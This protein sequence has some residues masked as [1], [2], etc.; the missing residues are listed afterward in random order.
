MWSGIISA[1]AFC[2]PAICHAQGEEALDFAALGSGFDYTQGSYSLGFRFTANDNSRVTALGFYDDQKNGLT[3]AHPVGIYDVITR[4]LV[5]STTVL[6]SDPITGFFRYHAITPVTLTAGRDYFAMALSLTE[7]YAVSV[8]TLLVSPHITFVG[9]AGV[10][11]S[12]SQE[13]ALRYPDLDQQA[14]GF[15][16]DFG[17]SFK[18]EAGSSTAAAVDFSALDGGTNVNEA[19]FCMGYLFRPKRDIQLSTLGYYDDNRDGFK[20]SHLVGIFNATTKSLVASTLV[21]N[22]D[23]LRGYF[24]YHPVPPVTLTAGT[25]YFV[26]GANTYD[27]YAR[28]VPQG[29]F[30]VSPVITLEAGAFTNSPPSNGVNYPT[31]TDPAVYLFGPTFEVIGAPH[32]SNIS[33]RVQVQTGANVT[34]GGFIVQGSQPKQVLVRGLGPTLGRYGVTGFLADPVLALHQT[35]AAGHD[36]LLATNDNWKQTQQSLIQATGKAPPIDAEAAILATL[37]AGN[38]TAILSGARGTT[39]VGLIEAYDISGAT[40]SILRN[41]STRG[42]VGSGSQ[43]LIGGFIAEAN[44]T[45]VVI[46]ALGPTLGDFGLTG[47]LQ[48]P[49][50]N[51][52]NSNGATIAT[53]DNWQLPQG[54]VIQTT[55]Y[56]PPHPTEAAIFSTLPA[57]N[58]T[59]VVSGKNGASGLALMELYYL[60]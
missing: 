23:P 19:A 25:D 37:P 38:Y 53:N 36:R 43:V 45:R 13:T 26:M 10:N 22:A 5:A 50:L 17:P 34:I 52:V 58:Y 1:S 60:P 41:I 49:V 31:S 29:D 44:N 33:S 2:L 51:L 32:L 9:F 16:G 42:F 7:H 12:D 24:H 20:E 18:L 14:P 54:A 8:T 46:R 6:P 47:V 56:A 40:N 35:D 27:N 15:H 48:D 30:N 55:G 39:G 21:S 4:Q 28:G 59:A 57:G 11:P 3:Q